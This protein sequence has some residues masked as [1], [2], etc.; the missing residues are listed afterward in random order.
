ML[1]KHECQ[2]ACAFYLAGVMLVCHVISQGNVHKCED[3]CACH[4]VPPIQKLHHEVTHPLHNPS[5]PHT[6]L[7]ICTHT[8]DAP[9]VWF[10]LSMSQ[11]AVLCHG[12]FGVFCY[13][14]TSMLFLLHPTTPLKERGSSFFC[15]PA[16]GFPRGL[17]L[18]RRWASSASLE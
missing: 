6:T 13:P 4:S 9:L 16:L 7:Q 5:P 8:F 14:R 15:T 10:I 3:S 12:G 18:A 2:S 1:G 11:S 17:S